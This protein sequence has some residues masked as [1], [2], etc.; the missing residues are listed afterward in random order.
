MKLYDI[1]GGKAV[2]EDGPEF[3]GE[4]VTSDITVDELETIKA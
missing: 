4:V 1:Q 3:V 2:T